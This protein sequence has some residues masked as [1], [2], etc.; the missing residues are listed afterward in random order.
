MSWRIRL[1]PI[2][3]KRREKIFELS[4]GLNPTAIQITE[5]NGEVSSLLLFFIIIY[6]GS[7]FF[8]SVASVGE[9]GLDFVAFL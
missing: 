1:F 9:F 4:Y 7:S 5:S 2:T 8:L 3:A 6:C